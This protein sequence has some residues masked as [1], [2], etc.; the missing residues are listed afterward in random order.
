MR[1]LPCCFEDLDLCARIGRR[2]PICRVPAAQVVHVGRKSADGA[3]ARSLLLAMENGGSTV[4]VSA[5]L[6]R[7][8]ACSLFFTIVVFGEFVCCGWL[9]LVLSVPL[10]FHCCETWSH[11][12]NRVHIRRSL[13][14]VEWCLSS[15]SRCSTRVAS[16]YFDL[17]KPDR[18]ES[19]A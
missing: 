3:S 1:D 2:Q 17:A 9:F 19:L 13:A 14:L 12:L 15:R 6:P 5:P 8:L 16:F 18:L 7:S 4:D 11:R 10:A